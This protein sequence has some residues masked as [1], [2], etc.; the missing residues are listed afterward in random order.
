MC[1]CGNELP[2]ENCCQPLIKGIKKAK[3]AEQLMRSRYSAFVVKDISF[4]KKT[5]SNESK[6]DFDEKSTK[7]WAEQANWLGLKILSLKK[8]Q[9]TDKTGVVEF[10]AKY[11]ISD[12]VLEHHEVSKFEKNHE[13]EWC[14]VDGDGHTHKEG[15]SH[16]HKVI[17]TYVR[18]EEKVGRNDPC[19]CGSGKK[20]KKCCGV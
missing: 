11:K 2:F 20:F 19:T 17:E 5:L 6:K 7:E 1:H 8:G 15:E 3:T 16:Q 12:E 9:E 18:P 13:G 10:V 14:F 4:L